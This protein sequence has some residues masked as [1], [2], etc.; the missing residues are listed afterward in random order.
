M[1]TILLA[2]NEKNVKKMLREMFDTG[3]APGGLYKAIVE[4]VERPMIEQVLELTEGNQ[5]KAA[6]MLGINRNTIRSKIKKLGIN[7]NKWKT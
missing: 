6:R 2:E 4:K 3:S 7:V 1:I 5:L